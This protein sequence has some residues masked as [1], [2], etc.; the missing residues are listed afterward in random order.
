MASLRPDSLIQRS[1]LAIAPDQDRDCREG[2]W[3]V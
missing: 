1:F 3:I 2:S